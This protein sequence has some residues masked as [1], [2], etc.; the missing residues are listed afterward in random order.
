MGFST[1]LQGRSAHEALLLRQD[2][3]LRLL[4]TMKRCM[5]LKVKCDREYAVALSAAV[6]Q[7]LKIDRSDE[8]SGS[9]VVSAWRSMMEEFENSSK[10]IK[11]NADNIESKTLDALNTMYAE[12]RKARKQYQEE[13]TRISHQFTHV[14]KLY[15]WCGKF[16]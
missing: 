13:H 9:L 1:N 15:F 10:L 2:A 12:K 11:Q 16:R 8:L 3:E 4:E 7:G 6:T 5:I 14:S